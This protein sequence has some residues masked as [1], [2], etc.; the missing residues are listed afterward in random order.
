MS[1]VVHAVAWNNHLGARLIYQRMNI[2]LSVVCVASLKTTNLL[3]LNIIVAV[4]S[5]V[6]LYFFDSPIELIGAAGISW[7]LISSMKTIRKERRRQT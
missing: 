6:I 5:L 2:H 1:G 4:I 3:K 7:V